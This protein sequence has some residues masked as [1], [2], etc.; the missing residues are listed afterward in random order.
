MSRDI[1]SH[2]ALRGISISPSLYHCLP[3]SLSLSSRSFPEHLPLLSS[4]SPFRKVESSHVLHI[5]CQETLAFTR[6]STVSI[7]LHHC[8]PL[9]LRFHVFLAKLS[10][11]D[12]KATREIPTYYTLW[13]QCPLSFWE[14]GSQRDFSIP[15][16]PPSLTKRSTRENMR[17]TAQEDRR[18]G[19]IIYPTTH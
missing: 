7:S 18:R 19:D 11:L 15:H 12:Q 4:S 6:L 13:V 10:L 14:R 16:S 3:L 2:S 5:F 17:E 9:S 1:S 8:L